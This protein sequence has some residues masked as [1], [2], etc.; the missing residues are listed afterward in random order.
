MGFQAETADFVVQRGLILK[1][2]FFDRYKKKSQKEIS[3]KGSKK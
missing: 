2:Q 1:Q 3:Q